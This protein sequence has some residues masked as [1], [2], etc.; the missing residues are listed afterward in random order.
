[1][2]YNLAHNIISGYADGN[3]R[4]NGKVGP[5]DTLTRLQLLKIVYEIS[6]NTCDPKTVAQD[7]STDWMGDNWARGYVECTEGLGLTLLDDVIQGDLSKAQAPAFR[8]EVVVLACELLGLESAGAPD[9]TLSDVA[10]SGLD[11][12]FIDMI[13]EL[14]DLGVISGN[15]DGTFRPYNTLNRAEAFK[16]LALLD[17]R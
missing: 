11:P 16:I 15:P 5:G 14:V 8:W 17:V 13:D 9:T 7:S 3:G 4:F 1:M 6:D 12:V 10:N 2:Y